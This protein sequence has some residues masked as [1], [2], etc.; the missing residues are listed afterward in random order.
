MPHAQCLA[1]S[2]CRTEHGT[3]LPR[4]QLLSSFSNLICLHLKVDFSKFLASSL[5]LHSAVRS[6]FQGSIP[7]GLGLLP[8]SLSEQK[9]A[10]DFYT[11][12]LLPW[13][14]D[15]G[16]RSP[17]VSGLWEWEKR[18]QEQLKA[19]DLRWCTQRSIQEKIYLWG[20]F[21]N[22]KLGHYYNVAKPGKTQ[23]LSHLS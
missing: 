20:H 1:M 8:A 13:A 16:W 2:V 7:A 15:S 9:E 21:W 22:H 14:K 19:W 23:D 17:L 10:S 12:H 18:G 5:L 6:R 3:F 11:G 4:K